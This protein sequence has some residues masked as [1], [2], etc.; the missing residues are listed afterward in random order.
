M[1]KIIKIILGLTKVT[2]K[3]EMGNDVNKNL[4]LKTKAKAKDLGH[5]AKVNDLSAKAKAKDLGP[6]AK[7]KDS[8]VEMSTSN[9]LPVF[10]HHF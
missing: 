7:A 8:R 9:F 3:K 1:S 5:K 2:F 10:L 6:K 4:R